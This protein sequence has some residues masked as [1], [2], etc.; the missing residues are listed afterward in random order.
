MA[1]SPPKRRRGEPLVT[2]ILQAT[3]SEI[4]R[5]GYENLSIEEVAERAGVNKTTI[6]RRWPSPEALA[7]SAFQQALD[8]PSLADKGSLRG[9][10][11]DFLRSFREMCRAPIMLSLARMHFSGAF[12]GKLGALIKQLCDERDR[13]ALVIFQRAVKRGELP[14]DA[15]IVL[16]RDIVLGSVHYILLL[17][18][19]HCSDERLERIVDV[20]LLGASQERT[21]LAL[22]E[23]PKA[24]PSAQTS[25][26]TLKSVAS[27]ATKAKARRSSKTVSRRNVPR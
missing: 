4:G 21:S 15:D 16:V 2:S 26:R 18:R 5:V 19:E 12:D 9:D 23:I 20:L 8:A 22:L 3:L 17:R 24:T 10:L 7:L 1:I 14:T 25:R 27:P 6:Y 13:E 11:I